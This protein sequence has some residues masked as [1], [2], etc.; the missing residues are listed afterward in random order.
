MNYS[1]PSATPS[2]QKLSRTIGDAKALI[3]NGSVHASK[4]PYIEALISKLI[5]LREKYSLSN[6][7]ICTCWSLLSQEVVSMRL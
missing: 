2:R 6:Y 5:D 3:K 1:A 7:Q 4:I